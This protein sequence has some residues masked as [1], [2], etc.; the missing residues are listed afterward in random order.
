M[1]LNKPVE[2]KTLVDSH[3]NEYYLVDNA[4]IIWTNFAGR[5]NAMNREGK[6]NF[7]W[8]IPDPELAQQI[9]A[10]GF[11]VR[12]RSVRDGYDGDE[13]DHLKIDISYETDKG[14]PIEE[15]NPEWLPEVYL[16]D[17]NDCATLIEK[18]GLGE[19][20]GKT[21]TFALFEFRPH[22]WAVGNKSGTAAK[23][24]RLFL[25]VKRDPLAGR[26]RF[27][28]S[29]AVRPNDY[30]VIK[31]QMNREQDVQVPGGDEVPFDI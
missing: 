24:K 18:E 15:I 27:R 14:I 16:V 19:L 12:H 3:G 22:D 21:I 6:R 7:N 28:D 10:L 13:F 8:V 1:D 30:S 2:F 25:K 31:T 17:D 5:E 9:A 11:N 29:G 23:L 26:F 20:D 4:Q